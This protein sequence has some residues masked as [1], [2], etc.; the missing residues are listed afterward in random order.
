MDIALNRQEQ[1]ITYQG[2]AYN[3]IGRGLLIATATAFVGTL[4]YSPLLSLVFSLGG[5]GLIFYMQRL[6]GD[7]LRIAYYAF[8]ALLGYGLASYL[9]RYSGEQ[10]FQAFAL[11]GGTYFITSWY[12]Q[13]TK[14]DL[15]QFSGMLTF[16][17][18][19]LIIASVFSILFAS[20]MLSWIINIGGVIIFSVLNALDSQQL[21]YVSSDDEAVMAS[22]GIYLNVINLFSFF[23]SIIGMS[24]DE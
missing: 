22:V 14:T 2:K 19:G 7:Q 21:K 20:T 10:V 5:L 18:I 13:R 4:F 12:G 24:S 23:M 8:T 17:L 6:S 15:S 1:I 11:T 3:M 16:A 9:L